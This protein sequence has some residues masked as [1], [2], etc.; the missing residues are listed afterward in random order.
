MENVKWKMFLVLIIHFA[1]CAMPGVYPVSGTFA[2]QDTTKFWGFQRQQHLIEK[3]RV[4]IDTLQQDVAASVDSLD[5]LR[6]NKIGYDDLY[7]TVDTT[8]VEFPPGTFTYI[9][10]YV[11]G[12]DTESAFIGRIDT[13]YNDRHYKGKNY[14]NDYTT[15]NSG[16]DFNT[17]VDFRINA[18]GYNGTTGE[19][20][21]AGS[22]S[23]VVIMGRGDTITSTNSNGQIYING[24][25]NKVSGNA[26]GVWLNGQY[27]H[28]KYKGLWVPAG[29][30]NSFQK[31]PIPFSDQAIFWNEP[32]GMVTSDALAQT[33]Y[34]QRNSIFQQVLGGTDS[35]KYEWAIYQP[36]GTY[37]NY[38]LFAWQHFV[39][40]ESGGSGGIAGQRYRNLFS[41]DNASGNLDIIFNKS[42][43]QGVTGWSAYGDVIIDNGNFVVDNY[44]DA[45]RL[46]SL[47]TY[48]AP[49]WSGTSTG[50][51]A[52]TARTSLSLNNLTNKAQV[53]LEDS[54]GGAAG[55]YITWKRLNDFTGS[56]NITTLGTITTGVWNA[57]AVTSS[58]NI[59]G[60]GTLDVRGGN[61]V[62]LTLGSDVGGNTRTNATN[63]AARAA[64]PHY[65]TAEEPV[66]IFS[67][68]SD[69]ANS[70]I[71][72]G[73]GLSLLNTATSIR[74]FT[75]GNTTT[76]TGTEAMRIE[77]GNVGIGITPLA[78]L[79]VA[80]TTHPTLAGR[81]MIT[82]NG[83]YAPVINQYRWTGTG[84]NY[85]Q[86]QITTIHDGAARGGV[87][88][89]ASSN[90]AAI[91]SATLVTVMRLSGSGNVGIGT[92]DFDG[93][94]AIGR[95]T[96]KATNND[97]S[98][99]IIVGRNS[100]EENKFRVSDRGTIHFDGGF[101]SKP[102]NET[103]GYT[104][105]AN[106]HVILLDETA[107]GG[108]VFM[109]AGI[110]GQQI[111]IKKKD[112]SAN[113]VTLYP[114]GSETIDGAGSYAL[115]TQYKYVTMVF[116]SGHWW[117]I[118]N[119]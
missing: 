97:G 44:I 22:A 103:N 35:T 94:P 15:F 50:L 90:G 88:I 63:K 20:Y 73:G 16:A 11:Y 95:V 102:V 114:D 36:T 85:Y 119:N 13:V 62:S 65:L 116:S 39:P 98:S 96:I 81:T 83:D 112:A 89:K 79:D 42:Q 7:L 31:K 41:I 53:E 100:G 61:I 49:Q 43:W 27:L 26:W 14:F 47:E 28:A 104:P 86:G 45:P 117:I 10:K 80:G 2:Q 99:N 54:T 72:I 30:D 109:N 91:G 108:D 4:N 69:V 1:L 107:G 12:K 74:F 40:W 21:Y 92:T 87:D 24:N 33:T 23:S 105:G 9:Y 59:V 60:G 106:D 113:A 76:T 75:A 93:T 110:E 57:G 115:A 32:I 101:Y 17:A 48:Y 29:S 118:G 68:S 71:N 84:T 70:V 34:P 18:P 46:D 64:V 3:N 111:T 25:H 56:S 55:N 37:N 58:G 51:N 67:G 8:I 5:S 19:N 77:N 52:S 82:D 38:G 66:A 6:V 78:K